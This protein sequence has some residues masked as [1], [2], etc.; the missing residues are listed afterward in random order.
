MRAIWQHRRGVRS[1]LAVGA[2][3]VIVFAGATACSSDSDSSE[4]S[5]A[6]STTTLPSDP[7]TGTPIRL[8]F[9]TLEGGPASL[10]MTREGAEAA[11]RYVNENAG[12]VAGHPIELVVCKQQEDPASATKC[13][14][15]MVEQNVSAVLMGAGAQGAVMLPIIAGAGLPYIGST[16]VSAPE[17]MSK[18]SFM[19]TGGIPAVLSA[20]AQVAKERGMKKVS[21]IIGDS[22][23]AIPAIRAIGDPVFKQAGVE[24]GIITIPL[25]T[26][27]PTPQI[28]AGLA[29]NPDAVT[30]LGDPSMCISALT[31]L[32]A[33]PQVQD[34][35]VASCLDSSVVDAVGTDAVAGGTSFGATD[36]NSDDPDSVLYR[37]VLEQYAPDTEPNGF[38]STGY[39]LVLGFARATEGITGEF[40]PE[41]IMTA[42]HQAKDVPLPAGGGIT[43]T[44]DGK[45]IPM[46]VSVCSKEILVGAVDDEAHVQDFTV[47][48]R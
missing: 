20:Q 8:G 45:A 25:G 16:G 15:D 23:G 47:Y 1:A 11:V 4:S 29:D 24:L 19:L 46:L 17:M 12:G 2:S 33:T 22:G 48:N 6:E 27:D 28:T 43:F 34:F 21:I 3:A 37:T 26:P 5:S 44:C 14:N 32:Q 30:I 18:E 42:M 36:V 9:I 39:Q 10:P 35:F 41:A 13:A 40:T 31:A 7:A 38:A